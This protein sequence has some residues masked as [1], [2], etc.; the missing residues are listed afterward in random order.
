MCVCVLAFWLIGIGLSQ[1]WTDFFSSQPQV[2]WWMDDKI[3][4]LLVSW[5]S[6]SRPWPDKT[7]SD[8]MLKQSNWP[9]LATILASTRLRF[10]DVRG[11]HWNGWD[12]PTCA[13]RGTFKFSN[14]IYNGILDTWYLFDA[15]HITGSHDIYVDLFSCCWHAFPHATSIS[16]SIDIIYIIRK[17]MNNEHVLSFL[18][19][20]F[21]LMPY[22]LYVYTPPE[23]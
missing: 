17:S 18:L 8:V 5:K 14:L 3:M 11:M 23:N 22:D 10:V 4:N 13:S 7:T 15:C 1:N 6:R 21:F 16:S 9:V 20:L 12:E 2:F 19:L